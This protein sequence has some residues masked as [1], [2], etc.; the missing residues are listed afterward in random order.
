MVPK[1][2]RQ[3]V[4]WR[5]TRQNGTM[6]CQEESDELM[7]PDRLNWPTI[8]WASLRLVAVADAL[9]GMVNIDLLLLLIPRS[10]LSRRILLPFRSG[11]RVTSCYLGS[12]SSFAASWHLPLL[13]HRKWSLLTM[14]SLF[15][16]WLYLTSPALDAAPSLVVT[17]TTPC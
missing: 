4:F 10:P 5:G 3:H 7:Q 1:H 2:C 6:R 13:L 12:T 14:S 9:L 15:H 11:P 17:T 16:G 8:G